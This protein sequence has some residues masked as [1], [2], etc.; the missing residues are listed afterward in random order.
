MT[1]DSRRL[2]FNSALGVLLCSLLSP[3]WAQDVRYRDGRFLETV[4]AVTIQR[5]D[6]ASS[7]EA[8]RNMPFLPGDRVWT[9][10]SGRAEIV[11][12]SGEV[13]WIAERSKVDS[14]GRGGRDQDERLGL[15]VFAGS[16]G[17]STACKGVR[18]TRSMTASTRIRGIVRRTGER[19]SV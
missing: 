14:L 3:A 4:G 8:I 15:R 2:T 18:P 16:F 12:A 19:G 13:L 17:A 1:P 6:E 5:A 11:F 7:D 9:D 10:D